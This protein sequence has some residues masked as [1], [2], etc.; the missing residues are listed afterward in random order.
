MSKPFYRRKRLWIPLILLVPFLA[1]FIYL[2]INPLRNF[3]TSVHFLFRMAGIE[4]VTVKT[5][6]QRVHY[7][8][9]GKGNPHTV[10]LLH[11]FGGNAMLTW[12]QL[13]RPLGKDF[14]VIAPDMLASNFVMLNPRTYSVASERDMVLN[15]LE[16]LNIKRADFVGLSVGGWVSLLIAL[17]H[18]EMVDR[19]VL[20]ESAGLNMEVPEMAKLTLTDRDAAKKFMNLL[21]YSPPPLPG[22]VLDAMVASSARIK[23][24]YEAVF[25]GFVEN[26]RP[27]ALDGRVGALIQPTLIIHGREDKVVPFAIGEKMHQLIP[28]SEMLVLEESGHAP[29]WDQ[30]RQLKKAI[31]DFLLNGR[32]SPA[33]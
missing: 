9:S 23:K 4:E 19:L 15:L 27:Y 30:P 10:V 7:Y 26:S 33:S 1:L 8:E 12:M 3:R 22:F 16:Y 31:M 20:V 14:H 25:M 29:V 6:K 5:G 18:P 21:F 2:A 17:E 32:K 24:K 11:G 13:L 28:H